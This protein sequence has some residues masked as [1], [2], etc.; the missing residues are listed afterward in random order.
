MQPESLERRAAT[1]TDLAPP[2]G[3][4]YEVEGRAI[5]AASVG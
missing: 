3:R 2:L 1:T 4:Y 5:A